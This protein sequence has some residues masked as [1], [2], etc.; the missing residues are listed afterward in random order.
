MRQR[1]PGRRTLLSLL[2]FSSLIPAF[3][4]NI[5]QYK[6]SKGDASAKYSEFS[7]GTVIPCKWVDGTYALLPNGTTTPNVT[8]SEGYPVGFSF[9]FGGKMVDRFLLSNSGDI[10]FGKDKVT[11]GNNCFCVSMSLVKHGLKAGEISY[12]TTGGEGNRILTV[13]WKNATINQ[14][15][16]YVGKYNLQF[17]FHEKDGRIEMAFKEVE[18]PGTSNGFDTSIHGWDGR[19]AV[20]LTASGLDKPVS[21]SPNFTSDMLNPSSYIKWDADDYDNGYAP[22]FVFTPESDKTAPKSAPT[23][24]NVVQNGNDLEI[25]CKKGADAASTVV[26][27]SDMPFTDADMPVDGET[28]RAAYLDSNGKQ[29]YPTRLGN[30]VALTYL[31]DSE[32]TTVYKGIDAG[33][34]YYVRAISA[35]GYPA[36]NRTDVAEAV[37]SASQAAPTSFTAEAADDRAVLLSCTAADPVIIAA[38]TEREPGYGKGYKG[39]FGVPSADAKVGDE[40]DGGGKV[41]YVGEAGNFRAETNPNAMTYFRAW[42]VKDGRLSSTTADCAAAPNV[43]FPFEPA[44]EGYPQGEPLRGWTALPAADAPYIPQSR[45]NGTEN[46]VKAVSVNG[47]RLVLRTPEMPLDRPLRVT[48]EW[49]METVRAAEASEDSGDVLL[50]KGNKPGEFGSGSLDLSAG[51]TLCRSVSNYDGTMTIFSGDE[52]IEGSSTFVPFEAEVPQGE[53]TGK[54]EI[55]FAGDAENTSILYLRNIRVEATGEAPVAPSEAPTAL[56]VD[57]DR[58]GFLHVSCEKGADAAYTL[59]MVSE[60]PITAADLPADGVSPAVGSKSGSATVIYWGQDPEVECATTME[61]LVTGYDCNYHVAAVSASTAPLFN[62]TA[63]TQTEYRTLPDAGTPDNMT[64]TFDAASRALGVTATRHPGAATSLLLVSEGEFDGE[65]EDG[66]TYRP[67][68]RVGNATVIYHGADATIAANH[69]LDGTVADPSRLTV[70]GYSC[71]SRGWFGS[72]CATA[73][74]TLSGISL[75]EAD[76]DL[77]AAEVYTTT[78]IRLR[79]NS[80]AALPAGLYIINGKKTLVK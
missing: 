73:G 13:Q 36:Y 32:I 14:S 4:G 67:G 7:D 10:Y 15:S 65:P 9:R 24:L 69:T 61:T 55:S 80:P 54:L 26:L 49:A 35:N 30:A 77:S 70:T 11:Y 45:N 27:I 23:D 25:S 12:K 75:I 31:N 18:T 64:A 22:V 34:T 78:G 17:R 68:E 46:V 76:S 60:T 41:I 63:I 20:L 57:E 44:I 16:G 59:V 5:P 19:D 51:G 6:V 37:F 40:I 3:A 29:W 42:T 47:Q 33:K 58:D 71:N 2:A 50:P 74:V 62:R 56:T 28:F 79:V 43:S 8:V 21:V 52:Y 1:Y 38:T 53:G 72:V 39:L 66:R 48:F